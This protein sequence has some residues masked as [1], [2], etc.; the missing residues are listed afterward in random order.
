M[1]PFILTTGTNRRGSVVV[2]VTEGGTEVLLIFV[3]GSVLSGCVAG[4]A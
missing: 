4:S 1:A 2:A 3:L